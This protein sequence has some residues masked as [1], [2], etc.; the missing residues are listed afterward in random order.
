MEDRPRLSKITQ[1]AHEMMGLY[2]ANLKCLGVLKDVNDQL[3]TKILPSVEW[4][5]DNI[6]ELQTSNRIYLIKE[7]ILWEF[8]RFKL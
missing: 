8:L 5:V 3:D 1:D 4:T 7:Q 6:V 2:K